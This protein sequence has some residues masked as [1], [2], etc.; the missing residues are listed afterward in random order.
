MCIF[1]INIVK[2]DIE[3][4]MIMNQ[5]KI[6][7]FISKQRKEKQLTQEQLAEKLGISKN[8]VSKWERGLSLM[9]ISLIEPLC[10]ILDVTIPEL[11]HGEIISKKE[12]DKKNEETINIVI[13]ISK[14]KINNYKRKVMLSACFLISLLPMLMNQFGGFR[15][16]QE[17]SG[18]I[19][20]TNPIGLISAFIFFFGVW[21]NFKNK[22]FNII[23]GAIGVIGII[24]SE[25]VNFFAWGYPNISCLDKISKCFNNALFPEFYIGLLFSIV[26][27]IVYFYIVKKK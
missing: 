13:T 8:A 9:D 14:E 7:K 5:E 16:V 17:I 26:M 21:Y 23:V 6:G 12:K 18:I 24:L 1:Y 27:L 20:L 25:V 15:D 22:Y 19:N 4:R 2:I 10:N 3:K 11:L